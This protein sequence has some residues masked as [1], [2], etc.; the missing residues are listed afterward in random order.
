MDI[1]QIVNYFTLFSNCKLLHLAWADTDWGTGCLISDPVICLY[2]I[3]LFVHAFMLCIFKI[4]EFFK[5]VGPIYKKKVSENVLM[6]IS[7]TTLA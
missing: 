5:L 2:I 1:F 4:K 7:G 6:K 3:V